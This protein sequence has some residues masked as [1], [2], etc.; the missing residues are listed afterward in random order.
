M[1]VVFKARHR[2]F[3]DPVALKILT[4]SSSRN[5]D[6]VRRFRREAKLL[7]RLEHPNLVTAHDIG[8]HGGVH[9]LVMDY[10]DGN[11][12]DQLVK[13]GGPMR[14]ARAVDLVIQA[15]RGLAA[16]HHR[17]IVHRDLKPAN[18]MVDGKGTVRVLDLG[19]ARV[20]GAS[21]AAD[22]KDSILDGRLTETGI[23]MGTVDYLSPE[24]SK[25]SKRVD[26]R[27]DIYS[28][29]CTF[30]YLLTGMPPYPRETIMQR[31]LAHHQDEIPSLRTHRPEIPEALDV[32]FRRMMAKAPDHRQ[33]SMTKVIESLESCRGP[34]SSGKLLLVFDNEAKPGASDLTPARPADNP[35]R[36]DTLSDD[37]DES[38][39]EIVP[40]EDSPR[41]QNARPIWHAAAS[42]V[43]EEPES[44]NWRKIPIIASA[45]VLAT[46]IL[47]AAF[48]SRKAG[49]NAPSAHPGPPKAPSSG[50]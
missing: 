24:Q 50:Q 23:I 41:G 45:F 21:V 19:L 6:S 12:L 35:S 30:H 32:A 44:P 22:G 9:F 25:D 46:A 28:L 11:D 40:I 4:P 48:A 27:A 31:L 3:V 49:S 18:I 17:Q 14:P 2:D 34:R 39:Y 15:A 38:Q 10:V 13:A 36:P 1:G 42:P 47:L 43:E 37:S 29:G 20:I 26:H 33:Q 5:A 7:A 16:A 8:E